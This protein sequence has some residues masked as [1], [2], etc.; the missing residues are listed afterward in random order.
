M[1]NQILVLENDIEPQGLPHLLRRTLKYSPV[2]YNVWWWFSQYV[3][4]H[5]EDSL[6]RFSEIQS[7]TLL[8]SQPSFAGW[9]NAF[10]DKMDLFVTLMEKGIKSIV[11]IQPLLMLERKKKRTKKLK[12]LKNCWNSILFSQ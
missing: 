5:P 11:Y 10:E 6:R 4:Q 7:D 2:P 12:F 9:D 3:I 1:I 8:L